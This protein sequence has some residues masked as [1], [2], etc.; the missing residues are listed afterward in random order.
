MK[1]L[2]RFEN[3]KVNLTT[4]D[5]EE[6]MGVAIDYIFPEDNEPEGLESISIGNIE[7]YED[8]IKTIEIIK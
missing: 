1:N 2:R 4:I 3:E 6:Y 7:F 5:G 8:E